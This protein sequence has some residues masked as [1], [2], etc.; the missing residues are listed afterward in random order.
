MDPG[1]TGPKRTGAGSW[2]WVAR[3]QL[4]VGDVGREGLNS[5]RM[6]KNSAL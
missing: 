6:P 3:S 4:G 2:H 1:K 5:H